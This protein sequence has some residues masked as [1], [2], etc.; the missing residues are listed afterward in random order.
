VDVNARVGVRTWISAAGLYCRRARTPRPVRAAPPRREHPAHTSTTPLSQLAPDPTPI[1]PSWPR[2]SKTAGG[3]RRAPAAH[4][5]PNSTIAQQACCTPVYIVICIENR[6]GLCGRTTPLRRLL[7]PYASII[8]LACLAAPAVLCRKSSER[9]CRIRLGIKTRRTRTP[10][11]Y[12]SWA[13][14]QKHQQA[15]AAE[16][17]RA[18]L[19]R[20]M[21]SRAMATYA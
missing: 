16:R 14:V 2:R 15:C 8:A 4:P 7:G 9:P 10:R 5:V 11:K 12:H 13:P 19:A 20:G 1:A 6:R 3:S 17:R 21:V 18:C